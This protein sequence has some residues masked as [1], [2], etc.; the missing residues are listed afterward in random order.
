MKQKRIYLL[1]RNGN[2]EQSRII[3]PFRIAASNRSMEVTSSP[4]DADENEIA[5]RRIIFDV[6]T[7]VKD[8]ADPAALGG[9]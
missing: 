6:R 1:S 4:E 8:T 9:D 2:V 5:V 3:S 7:L